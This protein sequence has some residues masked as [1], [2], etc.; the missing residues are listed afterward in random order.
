MAITTVDNERKKLEI[1]AAKI[2]IECFNSFYFFF[3]TFWPE[4][5]GDKYIDAPHIKFICDTLQEKAMVVISG[6][7]SMETVIINVPPGSSKST[8]ATIAFPMWVWLHGPWLAS[9][10]VSYSDTLSARHAKKARAITD[11]KKWHLLFDNIFTVMHGKAFEITTQNKKAIENNFKGERFNTS[12]GGTITGM[13]ADFIIKDDMQNP[14]TAKSD[15]ERENANHWDAE[16]LTS[17][18]KNPSCW[19][20]IIIAQRLHESD[21]CGY[22]LNKN[23]SI[24]QVCLPAEVTNA[25]KVLPESAISIYTDGILDPKRRP[26]PVLEITKQQMGSAEYTCQY[27]QAPFNLEEQD[28]QPSMFGI[29]DSHR[30]D[31]VFDLWIDG[32]YTEKTENDPSGIDLIAKD[33]NNIVWKESWD[34]RKKLPDLLAFIKELVNTKVFDAEKG[35]IFIEPKASGHSLADYIEF[36]TDYN[37]VRI[38]EHNN[39]EK[40]IVAS[41]KKARHEIIKPKAESHR[42]KIMKGNWN[43]EAITQICGFP[44]ASHDEHVDNLGYA[45]NHYYFNEN[46]WIEPWAISRLEDNL[47]GHIPVTITSNQDKYKLNVDYQETDKGDGMLFEYP[48]N[49]YKY[50]YICVLALKREGDIRGN[51]SILV[52]DRLMKSVPMMMLLNDTTPTKAAKKALELSFLYSNARLVVSVM[53]SSSQSQTEE[54]DL[55]HIAIKAARDIFYDNIYTR[56]KEHDIQKKREREYGFE[57]TLSTKR[58]VYYNLKELTEGNKI[59]ELPLPVFED[60]KLL[61]R[62]RETGAIDSKEGYETNSALA[63]AIALKVDEETRDKPCVRK[64]E[65]W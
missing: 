49:L 15:A 65:K 51:T 18:H 41:G 19:L 34:L 46:S 60:I 55:G 25:S 40:K 32:A 26:K 52:Y 12:V 1:E 47:V 54:T 56:L 50:R 38:G 30:D 5:S 14:K 63:Y 64:S 28:I 4:M 42:I 9:T 29:I 16:T 7:F 20:D 23:I 45:I 17:R 21:L 27:I 22:T 36:E 2:G 48:N 58:E 37:F 6:E 59:K 13:H 24:T 3:T 35:R 31:L 39:Q 33:G 10:N 44:R 57:T 62:K 43:D 53:N 61:E 8:I 11:S